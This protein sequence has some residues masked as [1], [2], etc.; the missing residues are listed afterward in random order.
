MGSNKRGQYFSH[1]FVSIFHTY[2]SSIIIFIA[3]IH[4]KYFQLAK[5]A[6]RHKLGPDPALVFDPD[7]Y[8]HD[9]D[10]DDDDD[11]GDDDVDDDD[12]DDELEEE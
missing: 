2:S 4:H 12:D 7:S 8:D 10:D 6:A 5:E 3:D 11:D 9:D 1:I